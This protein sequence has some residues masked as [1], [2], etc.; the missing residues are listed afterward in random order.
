VLISATL[1]QKRAVFP[2]FSSREVTLGQM[3]KINIH[4]IIYPIIIGLETKPVND[5]KMKKVSGGDPP[6]KYHS[7]YPT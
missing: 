3:R 6:S 4:F 7:Q 1:S 2:E 5:N